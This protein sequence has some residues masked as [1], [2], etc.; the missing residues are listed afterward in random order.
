MKKSKIEKQCDFREIICKCEGETIPI[1]QGEVL[2][3]MNLKTGG[4]ASFAILYCELCKK[5]RFF[6]KLN[7][8]IFIRDGVEEEKI[9]L[10][11]ELLRG[12]SR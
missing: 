6:P 4:H 3:H 11:T 9:W 2:E 8:E 10:Y 7:A 12:I 5:V 1:R